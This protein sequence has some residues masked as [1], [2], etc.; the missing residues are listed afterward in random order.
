MARPDGA[1]E[2]GEPTDPG[3]GVNPLERNAPIYV[4]ASS[5]Y[6]DIRQIQG[7]PTLYTPAEAREIAEEVL[8]AADACERRSEADD[9]TAS[10]EES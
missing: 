1:T 5:G 3:R 10:D 4:E 8:A 9:G 7:D 2:E 6:V